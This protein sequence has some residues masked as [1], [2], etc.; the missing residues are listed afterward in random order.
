MLKWFAIA[1]VLLAS[2]APRA[3][4]TSVLYHLNF[5]DLISMINGTPN[6]AGGD[7]SY[8]SNCAIYDIRLTPLD[9]TGAAMVWNSS[10][11]SVATAGLPTNVD[12]TTAGQTG[13]WS[14]G[15]TKFNYADFGPDVLIKSTLADAYLTFITGTTGTVAGNSFSALSTGET[16]GA[17]SGTAGTPLYLKNDTDY[18]EIDTNGGGTAPASWTLSVGVAK[19]NADGTQFSSLKTDYVVLPTPEPPN[20]ALLLAGMGVIFGLSRKRSRARLAPEE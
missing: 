12:G 14:W 7:C 10:N 19:L 18:I 17:L 2:L 5:T 9:S 6:F 1:V 3:S 11:W 15:T 4:A 16:G 13:N 20:A 8:L